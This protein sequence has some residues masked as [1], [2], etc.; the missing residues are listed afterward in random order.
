MM[1]GK[2]TTT[3]WGNRRPGWQT[4]ASLRWRRETFN[5]QKRV[6][7]D[8]LKCMDT[9]KKGMV[10]G[11]AHTYSVKSAWLG[12]YF[13]HTCTLTFGGWWTG[14][15]KKFDYSCRATNLIGTTEMQQDGSYNWTATKT[16]KGSL[17]N[18]RP[19][20]GGEWVVFYMRKGW[21]CMKVYLGMGNKSDGT[22]SS[23]LVCRPTWTALW[24]VSTTDHSIM[25]KQ[26]MVAKDREN[27]EMFNGTFALDLGDKVWLWFS[28][29]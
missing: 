2:K 5:Q 21:E 12:Y 11:E 10:W 13:W 16:D 18:D 23:V 25:R 20:R 28:G 8:H 15:I 19:G 4:K 7:E 14:G 17:G 22:Y 9:N 26:N 6:E 29:S 3:Q 1:G 24:W 27:V